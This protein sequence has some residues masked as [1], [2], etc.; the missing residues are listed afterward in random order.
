MEKHEFAV[1]SRAHRARVVF[2]GDAQRVGVEFAGASEETEGERAGHVLWDLMRTH[3][4]DPNTVNCFELYEND[5]EGKLIAS[6][7]PVLEGAR[8]V[9]LVLYR[10]DRDSSAFKALG[11]RQRIGDALELGFEALRKE[12]VRPHKP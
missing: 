3:G 11:S 12:I 1:T 6:W 2:S 5:A 9:W 10:A 8:V 4:V 7:R